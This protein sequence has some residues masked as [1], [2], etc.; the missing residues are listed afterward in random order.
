[1]IALAV[2]PSRATEG[3][4][5][6]WPRSLLLVGPLPPPSGG[7][8][9]QTLQLA[10]LLA[11]EGCDVTI[12]QVNAPYR[13][14]WIARVR[15]VRAVFRLI[16]YLLTLWRGMRHVDVVHVMANSGWAWHLFAAP[17]VWIARVRAK[18]VV[19][20]YRGG[21]AEPFLHRHAR[22]VVPTLRRASAIIVPSGFLE[23]VFADH[24]V[25][26]QVVPNVVDVQRFTPT[27]H[28]GRPPHLIVTRNL[29]DI[30][31]IPTALHAFV[32][33][34]AKFP[35][36]TLTVAGSGPRQAD[37][38]L[39]AEQLGIA[40]D[41]TFTGRIDNERIASLYR[42]ADVLLNP[43]RVDNMPNSLLEAMA[44]GVPIVTT[45]VG[46][47][48]YMVRQDETA[49]LVPPGNSSAM[50]ACVSSILTDDALARRLKE[51]GLDAVKAYTWPRVRRELA[52]VYAS[53]TAK[54][55]GER[56]R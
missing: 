52:A 12:A 39:L 26:A 56:A 24:G 28:D 4:A 11:Q 21:D 41:V 47:I 35:G 48:P 3:M 2:T 43:S 13:P 14:P 42:S 50:A 46:G 7:M 55:P 36:T 18:G 51:G 22:W 8:A 10:R 37:L 49:L 29:E 15:G 44:S 54:A 45:D 25:D 32:A 23:R 53:V 1:M 34:R 33:V 16:P 38:A 20:N 9:N 19:V 6:I 30:Y 27:A 31:D 17:A 5:T 40:A